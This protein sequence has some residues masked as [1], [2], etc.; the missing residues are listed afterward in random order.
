MPTIG[1]TKSVS[2]LSS[3]SQNYEL[4][5]EGVRNGG[6]TQVYLPTGFKDPADVIR[7]LLSIE[8][9]NP[10]I[11]T[12]RVAETKNFTYASIEDLVAAEDNDSTPFAGYLVIDF[13]K[14]EVVD[15]RDMEHNSLVPGW[16]LF[17]T[18]LSK[19]SSFIGSAGMWSG[20]KA[21]KV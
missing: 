18:A 13:E 11:D 2:A 16:Y 19:Q 6:G 4:V 9:P 10:R 1:T 8:H 14:D 17:S 7:G 20:P 3:M 12:I 21:G 15:L 5:V